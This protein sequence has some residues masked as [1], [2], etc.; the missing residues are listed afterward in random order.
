MNDLLSDRNLTTVVAKLGGARGQKALERL[1]RFRYDPR[2]WAA[3]FK[4]HHIT[5]DFIVAKLKD[6][7]ENDKSGANQ[8]SA[9]GKLMQ[10]AES[11]AP[12]WKNVAMEYQLKEGVADGQRSSMPELGENVSKETKTAL[13]DNFKLKGTG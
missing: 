4:N 2:V 9:L 8:I 7:A 3:A 1:A 12:A 10:M 6:I 5:P 11:L 13:S